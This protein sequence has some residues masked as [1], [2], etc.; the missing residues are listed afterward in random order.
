MG[1]IEQGGSDEGQLFNVNEIM[2]IISHAQNGSRRKLASDT[3][4]CFHSFITKNSEY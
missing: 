1:D 2:N 3:L 4:D